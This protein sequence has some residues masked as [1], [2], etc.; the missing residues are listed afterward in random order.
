MFILLVLNLHLAKFKYDKLIADKIRSDPG[1]QSLTKYVE[2]NLQNQVQ[3]DFNRKS[4][5][6]FCSI[7]LHYW[8][9]IIFRMDTGH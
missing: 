6:S 1:L 9:I 8:K 3:W 5:S 7:F 4:D 2:T